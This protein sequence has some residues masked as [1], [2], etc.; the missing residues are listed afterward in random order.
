MK[1]IIKIALCILV[2]ISSFGLQSCSK[3]KTEIAPKTNNTIIGKWKAIKG[4]RTIIREFIKGKDANSGT[5]TF[6]QTET[7][8]FGSVT[9]ITEPFT[10]KITNNSLFISQIA[11]IGFIFQLTENGDRLILFDEVNSNQVFFTFE[12]I[13]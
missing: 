10:W 11:D 7:N 8:Q 12:R 6:K 2:L 13:N 5:G 4:T 9:T 1:T 3:E